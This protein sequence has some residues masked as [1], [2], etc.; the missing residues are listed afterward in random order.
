MV[1]FVNLRSALAG[2][3]TCS[4]RTT[5]AAARRLRRYALRRV[6][7][8]RGQRAG[9]HRSH[10]LVVLNNNCNGAGF[11]YRVDTELANEFIVG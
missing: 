4:T 5:R 8:S 6:G 9:L 3:W 2:G 11:G 1:S 7:R 10:Q